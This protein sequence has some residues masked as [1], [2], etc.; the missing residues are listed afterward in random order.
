MTV[1]FCFMRVQ[2]TIIRDSSKTTSAATP[3]LHCF[4]I[5]EMSE[6]EEDWQN[7]CFQNRDGI[8]HM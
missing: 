2:H 1:W 5:D 4:I 7:A 3:G 8:S 6:K